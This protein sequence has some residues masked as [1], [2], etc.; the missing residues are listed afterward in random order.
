MQSWL[1]LNP[2]S[3]ERMKELDLL[4]ISIL[5][6]TYPYEQKKKGIKLMEPLHTY[7]EGAMKKLQAILQRKNEKYRV[8]NHT[9]GKLKLTS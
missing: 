1:N 6:R 3:D 4:C 5:G 2:F 9:C 8:I 7:S